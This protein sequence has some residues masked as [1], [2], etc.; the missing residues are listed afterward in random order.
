MAARHA[1]SAVAALVL[2]TACS[3]DAPAGPSSVPPPKDEGQLGISLISG[4][5]QPAQVGQRLAEPFTVRVSGRDGS[6][7]ND[8]SVSFEITSGEGVFGDWCDQASIGRPAFVRTD[9]DGFARVPFL[10]AVLGRTTVTAQVPGGEG[11]VTFGI[12]A[13]VLVIDFWFGIWYAGFNGPC[14]L[15]SDVTVPVGTAVEW[16]A[17]VQDER[18]SLQYTVTST[19]RPGNA[20]GFDSGLLTQRER[21]RFVP[22]V[23]GVW[24]TAIKSPD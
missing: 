3:K 13:T 12:E 7:M 5:G 20:A 16:K 17:G 22:A 21:F 6:A 24:D 23:S 10:P 1:I 4:D 11:S 2:A 15:S 19:S 8:V 9:P 18:S 14:S